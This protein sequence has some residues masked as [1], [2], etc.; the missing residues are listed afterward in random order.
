MDY[1]LRSVR[2][3]TFFTLRLSECQQLRT[4]IRGGK[5][6]VEFVSPNS[7]RMF[8][9]GVDR[10]PEHPGPV[11]LSRVKAGSRKNK[12]VEKA[13]LLDLFQR[14]HYECHGF[15]V[16][17]QQCSLLLLLSGI[18]PRTIFNV[19]SAGA[20]QGSPTYYTLTHPSGKNRHNRLTTLVR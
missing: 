2:W 17:T 10:G 9:W 19:S 5:R 3:N 1:A 14:L 7:L 15:P 18:G 16:G 13:A 20:A 6:K 8:G 12:G 11:L 4:H